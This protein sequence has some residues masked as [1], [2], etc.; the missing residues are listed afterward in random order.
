MAHDEINTGGLMLLSHDGS[1]DLRA[2][3][4]GAILSRVSAI[5]ATE[6]RAS[7][8][9]MDDFWHPEVRPYNVSGGAL[10]I[11]VKGILRDDWQY[12][13]WGITGYDYIRSAIRRGLA[14]EDVDRIILHVS[15]PGGYVSGCHDLGEY[16]HSVRGTKPII[17]VAADL[18]ASAAYWIASA[19]DQ[20]VITRTGAVGSIGV[21]T[22]HVDRSKYLEE[23]GFAVTAIYAGEKKN[24]GAPD[25]PLSERA[26]KDM[27][28]RVDDLYAAFC[29]S[30]S[31][32]RGLS[33]QAVRDTQAGVFGSSDAVVLGL[34]DKVGSLFDVTAPAADTTPPVNQGDDLMTDKTAASTAKPGAGAA[35][36]GEPAAAAAED[37]IKATLAR[38][39]TVLDSDEAK[40]RPALAQSLATDPDLASLP[41]E[42]LIAMLG[43]AAPEAK[44]DAG[45]DYH[46]LMAGT[47]NP[48]IGADAPNAQDSDPMMAAILANFK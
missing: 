20:V 16:I 5:S 2:V 46:A 1:A 26:R 48:E 47:P 13:C 12:S 35:P 41:A 34:A 44:A 27:Q 40:E 21:I 45:A 29:S 28:A 15:S 4:T 14:D 30:V 36:T 43:K 9:S 11:P 3:D 37:L 17:A 38:I 8:A 6:G 23:Q 7:A 24:D 39:S 10:V 18:A 31:R 19:A 42:K 33:E 25:A 22:G 32:N